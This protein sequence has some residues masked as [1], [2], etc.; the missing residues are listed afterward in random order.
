M[1]LN[2]ES[3]LLLRLPGEIRHMI[4]QEIIG[5]TI[6]VEYH[7]PM[8]FDTKIEEWRYYKGSVPKKGLSCHACSARISDDEYYR[9]SQKHDH[10]PFQA[11][12][13]PLY[14]MFEEDHMDNHQSCYES[15]DRYTCRAKDRRPTVSLTLLRVCRQMYLEATETLYESTIF[16]FR[17]SRAF[18]EFCN[19]LTSHQREMLRE[20]HASSARFGGPEDQD[21]LFD[22]QE[23]FPYLPGLTT[24]H[25]S[26]NFT[27]PVLEVYFHFREHSNDLSGNEWNQGLLRFQ[28]LSIEKATVVINERTA[29]VYDA[30]EEQY[31]MTVREKRDCAERLRSRLLAEDGAKIAALDRAARLRE[32]R[33]RCRKDRLDQFRQGNIQ[34][35]RS[36]RTLEAEA[37]LDA[38]YLAWTQTSGRLARGRLDEHS[39]SFVMPGDNFSR[40]GQGV[41]DDADHLLETHLKIE[42]NYHP[43][44][45][46][47]HLT[48]V[49]PGDP[50]K[51]Q[52]TIKHK[53][54]SYERCQQCPFPRLALLEGL[55]DPTTI[56]ID[57]WP[58][59]PLSLFTEYTVFT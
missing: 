45:S 4:W 20:V 22:D 31:D 44:G 9:E 30:E 35:K 39:A 12:G 55:L 8:Q 34:V 25:V 58:W 33:R 51:P 53:H 32:T 14:K 27:V 11:S 6:H 2:A 1:E 59:E 46:L 26:I 41:T 21:W 18:V 15:I 50:T 10:N 37:K 42:L 48:A 52:L 56:S 57:L 3:S 36:P 43:Q 17:N 5:H 24:L 16:A 49:V 28:S 47:R 29:D 38:F 54:A 13:A 40:S 7:R 19:S 23:T